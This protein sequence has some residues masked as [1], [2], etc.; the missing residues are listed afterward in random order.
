M[1]MTRQ[2]FQLITGV[3][4]DVREALPAAPSGRSS[5]AVLNAVAWCWSGAVLAVD[6]WRDRRQVVECSPVGG[7]DIAARVRGSLTRL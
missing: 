4:A 1:I 2:R 3:I 5:Q 6:T 7:D